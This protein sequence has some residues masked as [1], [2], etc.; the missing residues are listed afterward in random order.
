MSTMI[1]NQIQQQ[2]LPQ[3]DG[4]RG[5]AIA[6][7]VLGHMLVFGVGLGFTKLGPLPPL[8]VVLFFVLSGFLITRIL[9]DARDKSRYYLSFYARRALRIWPL[10]FLVLGILFWITNHRVAALTFDENQVRWPFFA[11]YVQNI[12][13]KNAILFGPPALGITWSLAVEEQFY[14]TWPLIV[15]NLTNVSLKYFLVA[16]IAI[17]PFARFVFPELGY[18]PYINPLC[19]FDAMAMGGLVAIWM[20]EQQPE[21]GR[22]LRVAWRV[23]GTSAFVG[24]LSYVAGIGHLLS[25]TVESALWTAVLL[26]ALSSFFVIRVLS[27]SVLR[28]LGKISYCAYLTHFIFAPITASLW[29][30]GGIGV[31]VFRVTVVLSVT[32]LVGMLSWRCFEEPLLRFKRYFPTGN[33]LAT[34]RPESSPAMAIA[35]SGSTDGTV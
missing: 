16:L 24:G 9:L 1:H 30:G 8:G 34:K 29:P 23:V 21:R 11:L 15:R 17:A 26:G 19:R 22:I 13:Y 32:C 3:L 28:F 14:T 2:H 35:N 20:T 31:R 27:N 12:V 6:I 10:Y 4:L 7:V 5:V 25:K 18:D 33:A